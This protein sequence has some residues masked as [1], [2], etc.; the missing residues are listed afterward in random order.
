MPSGR[1]ILLKPPFW[2]IAE[3]IGPGNV[4]WVAMNVSTTFWFTSREEAERFCIRTPELP[5]NARPWFFPD[6][7]VVIPA[8]AQVLLIQREYEELLALSV[9]GLP[10]DGQ[11]RVLAAQ[12]A[13]EMSQGNLD[14]GEVLVD[15][16]LAMINP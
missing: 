14:A 15:S 3:H 11:A 9:E 6:W 4:R 10:A 1:S 16:A 5:S 13:A 12:G 7:S 8:M 2:L